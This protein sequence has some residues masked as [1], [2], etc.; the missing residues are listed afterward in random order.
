MTGPE[1]AGAYLGQEDSTM[2][3]NLCLTR[4]GML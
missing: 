1:K 4:R 2:I 3:E